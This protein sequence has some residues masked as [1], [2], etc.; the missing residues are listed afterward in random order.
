MSESIDFKK[1]SEH[2]GPEKSPGFLLWRVSTSWR[3][4]IESALKQF[5]LTHP[6]FV[7]LASLGWLTRKE[8][9]VSQARVGKMAGIDPNTTSQIIRGL[10]K[11]KFIYREPSSD[12][13]VKN[14]L[15]TQKGKEVLSKALPAVESEDHHFFKRLS[16]PEVESLL[17]LFEKLVECE[18]S[19]SAKING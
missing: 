8:D 16:K 2:A 11:K 1:I 4:F 14:P 6:Q 9:L 3:N 19:R 13:R 10:E 15:L 7:I 5:E 18:S 17:L 12:G